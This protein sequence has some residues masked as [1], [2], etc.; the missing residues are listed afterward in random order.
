M[1]NGKKILIFIS[2][3][4]FSG[5]FCEE[6]LRFALGVG[7]ALVKHDVAIVLIGD[8]VWF[9]LKS[10]NQRDFEKYVK[11]FS[12]MNMGLIIEKESL[13]KTGL[14]QDIIKSEFKIMAR[15]E[16]F[17]LIKGSDFTISF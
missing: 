9:S 14:S 8:G 13:E 1:A 10:L 16:I 2:H 15:Q 6:G 7:N 12:V 3:T 11:A 4:P 17:E 5:S